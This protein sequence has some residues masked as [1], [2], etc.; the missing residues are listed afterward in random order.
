MIRVP[1]SAP[2]DN[3]TRDG[4]VALAARGWP[5][6]PIKPRGKVPLTAHGVKDASTDERTI[7]HWWD[8]W[9]DA[10]VG[11]ACGAPGPTVLDIDDL[12]SAGPVLKALEDVHAPTVATTRGRHVYFRGL[13]QSTITLPYG[14]L[15][16]QGSYVVAPPS[17]H[18]SGK[19][20]VWLDAINGAL[21]PVPPAIVGERKTA[22]AGEQPARARVPHGERHSHLKDLAV[23][24]VRSGVTHPKTIERHLITEYEEVCDKQ[25]PAEPKYFADMAGW[26]ARTQIAQRER[27][28]STKPGDMPRPP[29]FDAPLADHRAYVA[30][31]GGW[32]PHLDI[33]SVQRFGGRL[34]DAML[35]Y[36]TN[37]LVID[38]ARQGDI[39][40]RAAWA[41][42]VIAGTNGLAAPRQLKDWELA[43]VYRSLCVLAGAP[44]AQAEA[45]DHEELLADM[46][47]LCDTVLGHNIQ[48]AAS[49]FT[50]V[51][52]LRGRAQWNPSNENSTARPALIIDSVTGDRYVRAGELQD[53]FRF[54]GAGIVTR[55]FPGRMSMIGL[56]R[57]RLNGREPRRAERVQR[58]TNTALLYRLPRPDDEEVPSDD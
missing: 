10:N 13:N 26:A 27:T 58:R 56:E 14:E 53:Y 49:I 24:L 12:G 32:A 20:Y 11:V 29:G 6:M 28:S 36:L 15:R 3:S 57:A 50:L 34:V 38:F 31:A 45:E 48:D 39:T 30:A 22:G 4:A 46:L 19:E 5:V 23:R 21:P 1:S 41:K 47:D 44:A 7:L 51:E 17:I 54:R 37:G 42:T 55:E 33:V 35:I 40:S 8:K 2:A 25:P 52:I 16:G 9:P 18:P 43:T